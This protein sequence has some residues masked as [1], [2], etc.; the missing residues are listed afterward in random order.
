MINPP[1]G[2]GMTASGAEGREPSARCGRT[3]LY[4]LRH[5]SIKIWASVSV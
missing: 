1:I 3:V 5:L 2:A 4:C